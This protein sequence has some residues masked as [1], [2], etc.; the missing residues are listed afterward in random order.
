MPVYFIRHAETQGNANNVWVGRKDEPI[1]T[2]ACSDLHASAITLADLDLDVIYCSPLLR[3]KQT[4]E[5]IRQYQ[6]NK[7]DIIVDA[8][9]Q[10]RDFG[11]FEGRVKTPKNRSRLDSHKSVETTSS[12]V[13]RIAPL[14]ESF[15]SMNVNILV[16]SHSAVYKCLVEKMRYRA[17]PEKSSL[18]NSEW[19]QLQ[20]IAN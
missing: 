4:A 14:F 3:A 16:V 10:E 18:K 19:V 11:V 20:C 1:M 5:V 17:T 13:K 9:L 15:Y 8:S 12:I 2:E 7:P 6:V